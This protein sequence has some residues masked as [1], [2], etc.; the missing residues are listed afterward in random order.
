MSKA[1]PIHVERTADGEYLLSWTEEFSERPVEVRA[2]ARPDAAQDF[3]ANLLPAGNH[4][5]ARSRAM[6]AC[7]STWRATGS[8]I[9]ST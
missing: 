4:S 5:A 8:G 7:A 2:H 9:I 1:F 3:G 6:T